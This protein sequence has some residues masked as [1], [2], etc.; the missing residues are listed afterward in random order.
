MA[1][2][3]RS[4]DK[5]IHAGEKLRLAEVAAVGR[6]AEITVVLELGGGDD[7]DACAEGLGDFQGFSQGSARRLGLSAM[8]PRA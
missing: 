4:R 5:L 7:F 3:P 1:A 2:K 6:V 8:T